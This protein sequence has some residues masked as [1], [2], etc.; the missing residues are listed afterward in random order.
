[1]WA[2]L[3]VSY[4]ELQSLTLPC[5]THPWRAL[6]FKQLSA[7]LPGHLPLGP[8]VLQQIPLWQS[9]KTV[10]DHCCFC[11]TQYWSSCLPSPATC[12]D[13]CSPYAQSLPLQSHI[14]R[15]AAQEDAWEDN[16]LAHLSCFHFYICLQISIR[17]QTVKIFSHPSAFPF[18]ETPDY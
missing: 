16:V 14:R 10:W 4:L 11:A 18:E 1:M 6:C 7:A 15:R 9:S 12:G 3:A 2:T 8:G 13:G 5:A 17:L